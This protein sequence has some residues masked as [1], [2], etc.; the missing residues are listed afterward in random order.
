MRQKNVTRNFGG[1]QRRQMVRS[2]LAIDR[3]DAV[4]AAKA[5]QRRQRDFGCIWRLGK[6][7]FTKNR[8][9]QSNAV[10]PPHQLSIYPSLHAVCVTRGMEA[11]VGINH[12]R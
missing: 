10:Q 12:G 11:D 7:G 5:Y 6:H 3:L 9:S 8:F 1:A 4:L 2:L